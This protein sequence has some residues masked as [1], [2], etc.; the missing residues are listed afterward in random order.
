MRLDLLNEEVKIENA[1]VGNII[2]T[3][4]DYIETLPT[5]TIDSHDNSVFN[6]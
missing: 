2:V 6:L 3:K 4:G 5:H 1:D